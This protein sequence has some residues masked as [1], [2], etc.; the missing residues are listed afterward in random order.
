MRN[1]IFVVGLLF[2]A[3]IQAQTISG[4]V[5][6][7]KNEPLAG[8]YVYWE[9]S[10]VVV[11]TN[12]EGA[13]EIASNNMHGK[14]LIASFVGHVAD[15][16]D[17]HNKRKIQFTLKETKTLDEV[18]VTGQRGGVLISSLKP[19]KV[20]QITT[21]ELK[22]A[23]CCDLAGCFDTQNTVQPQTTNIITNSKELRI[24][25]LS[26]VYNQVLID[27][28][29]MIQGLTYTYGISSIPGTMVDN[30]HISKGANSVIQG[31]ESISGQINVETKEPAHADRLF[32]NA[33]INSYSEKHFNAQYSYRKGKWGNLS[34]FHTVQPA[35]KIDKDGDSFLDLP[36]LT[37]YSL[38]NKWQYGNENKWGWN[39]RIGLRFLNESRVGGQELYNSDADKGSVSIY[40]QSVKINQPEIWTKTAYRFN[41]RHSIAFLF[42]GFYQ[43]QE[44]VFGT[45]DYKAKQANVYGNIQHQMHFGENALTAG[46]S[47]RHLNLDETVAFSDTFLHRTYNGK[48]LREENIPGVFAENTM[49]LLNDRMALITGVRGDYHNEHGFIFTPRMLVKFD[50]TPQTIVRAS[51][52]TGW[53]TVNLFSENIGLLASSRDIV[54]Q[55]ELQPEKALNLGL[56]FTQKFHSENE[57][58]SGY[59][60][61]DYYRTDFSNLISPD[62]DTDPTK[63]YVSNYKG[64]SVSNG[65]Q[66]ELNLKLFELYDFKVGYNFL[67]VFSR[68][69]GEK[70]ILP[71]NPKHKVL[72]SFSFKP[73]SNRFSFDINMHWF[74]E[75]R[76]P[77]TSSNP[78][79]YQRPGFS[80]P[81]TLFNM[82]FTYNFKKF[83]IY[84]GCENIFNYRQNEPI[85]SWQ[86]PFSPYFDTSSAWGPTRGRELYVGVRFRI[87]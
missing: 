47:F 6:S 4:K 74:G 27:G 52:G 3:I 72:T 8:A 62:Y 65:F 46:V 2:P 15:T 50:I 48:Y 33:Y 77:N 82:Q 9:G 12:T 86:N 49:H 28:L 56:N 38:V 81:Y 25:G 21:T 39:S 34:A 22:K 31:Y 58:V 60:S 44:S 10:S 70:K 59:F 41:D 16:V 76:L 66:A 68:D 84:T 61:A 11:S 73:R 5:T 79:A 53:R 23:A 75:Q 69:N 43:D 57:V 67:D 42:S 32:L 17:A 30:I 40:G 29:P 26:G 55:E 51:A 54:I 19:L 35:N 83:E 85:I 71:F 18:V 1:I 24:L 37:R 87:N 14:R 13:F 45:V 36:L 7:D 63:A 80:E 78:V 20:E 64:E